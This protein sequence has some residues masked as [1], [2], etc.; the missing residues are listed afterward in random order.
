MKKDAP[1]PRFNEKKARAALEKNSRLL[2]DSASSGIAS[3]TT[4]SRRS[5]GAHPQ[6]GER[7]PAKSPPRQSKKKPNKGKKK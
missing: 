6:G 2:D 1:Q 7:V 4:L 5:Y 3:D